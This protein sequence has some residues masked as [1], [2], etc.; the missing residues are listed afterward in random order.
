MSKLRFFITILLLITI[1]S[2]GYP[3]QVFPSGPTAPRAVSSYDDMLRLLEDIEAGRIEHYSEEKLNEL[4]RFVVV[5]AEQGILPGNVAAHAA[6]QTDIAALFDYEEDGF[7]YA[8]FSEFSYDQDDGAILLCKHHKH[9][10]KH[11]KKHHHHKKHGFIKRIKRF[12]KKHKKAIIIGVAVVL[13]VTVVV[14]AITAASAAAAST[15]AAAAAAA[16][17]GSDRE[18]KP[19]HEE[20]SPPPQTAPDALDVMSTVEEAP[21]LKA[22][23][24]EHVSSFKEDLI[25]NDHPAPSRE[26]ASF[27]EVTRGLGS[28]LAHDV[29]DDVAKV[30]SIGPQINNEI[31]E[32][33]TKICPD[34]DPNPILNHL[35]LGPSVEMFD[36]MVAKGHEVIDQVFATDQAKDYTPEAKAEARA[37]TESLP[38][39]LRVA[40]GELPPPGFAQAKAAKQA[41]KIATT[42]SEAAAGELSA[43]ATVAKNINKPNSIWSARKNMNPVENAFW[44]WKKHGKEFQELSNARDYVEKIRNFLSNPPSGTLMKTRLNGEIVLYHPETNTFASFTKEGVPKTLFKPDVSKHK[45]STNLEYFNAQ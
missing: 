17:S 24:E 41:P 10:H 16:A 21:L 15:A 12:V 32:I 5:L 9:K 27:G 30:V 23:F 6:L 38:K 37:I 18:E 25:E 44:H 34:R 39:G 29:L 2:L 14:V 7:E 1:P 26:T 13:T 20:S 45:Y 35:L 33:A 11:D 36:A 40:K 42:I 43:S 3:Q 22:T 19:E 28:K 8:T 4:G 31:Q